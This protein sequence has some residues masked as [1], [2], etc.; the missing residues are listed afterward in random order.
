[1]IYSKRWFDW[2]G[3][4]LCWFIATYLEGGSFIGGGSRQRRG[5]KV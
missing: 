1:M 5:D 4:M 3:H 2:Q